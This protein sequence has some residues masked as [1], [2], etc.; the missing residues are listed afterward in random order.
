MQSS[1]TGDLASRVAIS[2]KRR[3]PARSLL[4]VV[5]CCNFAMLTFISGNGGL[6]FRIPAPTIPGMS[7]IK[8]TIETALDLTRMPANEPA[9]LPITRDDISSSS[10]PARGHVTRDG[11]GRRS[12]WSRVTGRHELRPAGGLVSTHIRLKEVRIVIFVVNPMAYSPITEGM[13]K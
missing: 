8:C 9:Q 3:L 6:S 2:K 7:S 1:A 13:G 11:V 12:D 5:T 10:L 4:T